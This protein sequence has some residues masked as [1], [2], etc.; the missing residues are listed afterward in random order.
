M[1]DVAEERR[2]L[3]SVVTDLQIGGERRGSATGA[4]LRR[5]GPRHRRGDRLG[6]GRA[7]RRRG[8]RA[9]GGCGEPLGVGGHRPARRGEILRRAF[10]LLVERIDDLALLDDARDG[11]AAR[12]GSRAR[13][14]TR[15]EFFRWFA[16]EAV[17]IDGR[18][19]VAPTGREP[20]PHH[21]PAR[22]P[23]PA[24]HALE[25]PAWPWAPAR[26]RR[27]RRRLHHGASSPRSQTP[28]S[29]LAARRDPR[30]RPA[31]PPGVLNVV[32]TTARRRG[33]RA[34]AGRPPDAQAVVH[35]VDRG[36]ARAASSRPPT[37]CCAPRWSSAATPR[38]W[39]SRTPTSTPP[40]R[41]RCWPRCA[42][43]ARPAPPPTASYVARVAWP[44]S[45]PAR[46]AERM[47]ALKV[48]P[49]HRRRRARSGR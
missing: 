44:T 21:A 27:R 23:V 49:R 28:L 32:T 14:P 22:R 29:M 11:Q 46:L 40:S 20:H 10:E 42:T 19:T 43:W 4:R 6:R 34:A 1:A 15:A 30:A 16:E 9:R 36:R 35:R 26:S 2:V 18:Y 39:C 25:L 38:S 47:G 3:E 48:G 24:H 8:R 37:T 12:R 13:S 45:S 33:D 5:R 31:C 41:A 17:R 7:P